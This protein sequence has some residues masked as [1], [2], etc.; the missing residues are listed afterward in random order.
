MVNQNQLERRDLFRI[1]RRETD[2][3]CQMHSSFK[4]ELAKL[5]A[6]KEEEKRD[7]GSRPRQF[8]CQSS[9]GR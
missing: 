1:G 6:A 5:Y 2:G 7:L 9:S 4:E 8:S 3:E